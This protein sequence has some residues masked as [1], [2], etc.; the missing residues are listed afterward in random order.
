MF[1]EILLPIL[2]IIIVG[3]VIYF[4]LKERKKVSEEKAPQ[5]EAPSITEEETPQP[6]ESRPEG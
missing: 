5:A 1:H 2:G 6:P 3:I 4:L